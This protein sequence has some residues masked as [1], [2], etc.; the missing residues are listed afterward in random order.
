MAKLSSDEQKMLKQLQA[1][2]EAPDE[3][4][5]GRSIRVNIDL[6]D[7]NQV[8]RAIK[9]GLLPADEDEEET[10]GGEEEAEE[11]PKRR[12]FFEDS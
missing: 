2:A 11:T 4:A 8:K 12:G 9:W 3:P 5:I 6:S 1:K 7:D 10:D